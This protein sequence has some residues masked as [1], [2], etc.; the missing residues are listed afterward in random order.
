MSDEPREIV[1]ASHDSFS[2]SEDVIAEFEA[3][4]N[5]IVTILKSGDAGEALTRAILT[6]NAPTADLL[7]G[8]DN[9]FLG[10]ALD[11]DIFQPYTSPQLEKVPEQYRLDPTGHVMPV[12]YGFVA[13]NYDIA[14]MTENYVTPPED[15]RP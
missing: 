10:R 6:K 8:I 13:L 11:E 15:L 12:D 4:H 14:W 3:E 9:S 2:I 5:A 1:V 7:Y